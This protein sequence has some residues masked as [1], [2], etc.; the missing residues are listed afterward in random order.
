MSNLDHVWAIKQFTFNS[1]VYDDEN[2]GPMSWDWSD[3]S[4]EIGDRVADQIYVGAMLIPE[5]D[6]TVSVTIRDPYAGITPGTK[7]D[8]TFVLKKNDGTVDETFT[9]QDLVYLSTSVSGRKS[10]VAE[11]TLSF[12][13]EASTS[14]ATLINP[15]R[16]VR[17]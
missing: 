17:S 11:S 15:N 13:Y 6:L 8:L 2:G 16:I 4:N 5:R 12:R 7:S 14:D 10:T 1:V 9:I 3:T